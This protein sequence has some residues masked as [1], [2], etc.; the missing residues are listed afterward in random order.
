MLAVLVGVVEKEEEW[1]VTGNK[2][3]DRWRKRHGLTH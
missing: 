1:D 3:M 2:D